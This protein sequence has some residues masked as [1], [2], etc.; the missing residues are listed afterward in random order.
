MNL[1]RLQKVQISD[2]DK[3]NF[4]KCVLSDKP[5]EETCSLFDDQV[6]VRF[7]ALTV[8]ENADVV[9]QIVRDKKNGLASDNDAYFITIATYRLAL[10][11]LSIDDKPY[12]NINKG[13]FMSLTEDGRSS[14]VTA[15]A[16]PMQEWATYKLSMLLD[17][18]QQFEAKLVKLTNEVQ[19]PNFWKASAQ[20]V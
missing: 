11:L 10:S 17:A 14:Y 4:F 13:N 12:S 19:S 6:K 1:D 7:K 5:Y 20:K 3:D 8:Q 9:D 2:E 16:K 15:R 18:F